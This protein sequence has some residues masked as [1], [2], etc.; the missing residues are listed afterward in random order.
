MRLG[1]GEV[2]LT[3]R[4]DMHNADIQQLISATDPLIWKLWAVSRQERHLVA[5]QFIGELQYR[6]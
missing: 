3:A 6:Y 5:I 1:E 2:W 4:G